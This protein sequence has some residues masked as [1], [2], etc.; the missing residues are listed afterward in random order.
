MGLGDAK[1]VLV[2]SLLVGYPLSIAAFLFSFWT[3]CIMGIGLVLRRGGEKIKDLIPFG[4]F[5]LL[6]TLL[7]YLFGNSFLAW[8]GLIYLL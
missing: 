4:P 6:G 2:L 5:I 1:L 7:A 8:S 3:G